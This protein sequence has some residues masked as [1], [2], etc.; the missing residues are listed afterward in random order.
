VEVFTSTS[1]QVLNRAWHDCSR[2]LLVECSES[3]WRKRVDVSAAVM[4]AAPP[5]LEVGGSD[6]PTVCQEV[7]TLKSIFSF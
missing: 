1:S 4:T 5:C 6:R 2:Q 7:N 3:G